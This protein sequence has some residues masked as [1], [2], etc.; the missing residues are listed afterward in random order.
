MSE[1]AP[2]RLHVEDQ[3]LFREALR[4]TAAQTGFVPRLIEKDYFCTVV[5]AYLTASEPELV[6]RGGTCLAKIH[7][8][9]Y[10][11]SED[12]DFIIATPPRASRTERSRLAAKSKRVAGAIERHVPGLRVVGQLAGAN[13]SSQYAG[14]LGYTSVLGAHEETIKIE[15]GLREP[16]L[17][18]PMQG[19]ART[20]LIDPIANESLV[21]DLPLACLSRAEAMAEKLRAALSRRDAAVRDFYDVDHAA[22]RLGFRANAPEMLEL[23]RAKLAV[24]GND[25]VDVSAARIDILR[26]QVEPQL[27]PVLRDR[28]LA[29]FDLDRAFGIVAGVAAALEPAS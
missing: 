11:L 25:P 9:F 1:S 26:S 22:R 27:K 24:P 7:A 28:D 16:L 6:F 21:P 13:D 4:F 20:L 8:E 5:L 14:V 18:A 19:E 2:L 10:R 15:I 29:E 17:L 23:V 3:A 12:I